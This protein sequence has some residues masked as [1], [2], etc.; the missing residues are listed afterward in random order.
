MKVHLVPRNGDKPIV[1]LAIDI[2]IE[3][4]AADIGHACCLEQTC[5]YH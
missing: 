2:D 4:D 3:T 1:S 5:W